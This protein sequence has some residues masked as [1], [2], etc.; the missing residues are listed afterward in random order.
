MEIHVMVYRH[1]P[2]PP[3]LRQRCRNPRCAGKLKA[4][5]ASPRN[6]FC[7][8]GCEEQFYDGRCRVCEAKFS[9]KTKRRIVCPQSRC[10]HEFQ[11]HPEQYFGLR[12][13]SAPLGHNASRN[14]IKLGL[15][16]GAKSGRGWRVVAG[17]E[18]PEINIR[19]PRKAKQRT[20]RK[21]LI[22]RNTP[23]I[24]II[25]GYK[26]PGAPKVDLRPTPAAPRAPSV[27]VGDG[28]DIPPFLRRASRPHPPSA[29]ALQAAPDSRTVDFD[30]DYVAKI[31]AG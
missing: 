29:P 17:P 13:P 30:H 16:I 31:D 26:F 1:Q 23:P 19:N 8:K 3:Q 4:P 20:A 24:N 21:A 25:G 5:A 27:L 12:Y 28:L 7:C 10:R 18:V 9:R 2:G 15:K 14:S 11:R 6:A 22:K